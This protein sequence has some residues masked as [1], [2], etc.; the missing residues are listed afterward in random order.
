MKIEGRYQMKKIA[1]GCD[2]NAEKLKEV[3]KKHLSELGY[4]YED[5]GSD[6]TI[7]A[8]VAIKVAEH[9]AAGKFSE[10]ILICGTGIGMCI[11]AN[12]VPGAYAALCSDAYSAERAKK[13]NNANVM[14]IGSQVLGEE[15]AKKLV[16][17]WLSSEYTP[18]GRSD[19]KIWRIYEYA[20]EH[21]K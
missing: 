17:I 2:P 5:F 21:S 19:P 10:G 4:E 13:S 9:V 7:Y 1:I 11:A 3:I 18:G 12:K 14:T 20:K 8:N 6:D 15:L 16:S